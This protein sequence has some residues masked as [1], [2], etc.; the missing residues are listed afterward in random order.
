MALV[1]GT[2][3]QETP[4]LWKQLRWKLVELTLEL[5]Q[6]WPWTSEWPK[7]M[8]SILPILSILGY[9]AAILGI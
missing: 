3:T 2:Q 9:R 1:V 4:Y 6:N 5:S 8:D 7:I